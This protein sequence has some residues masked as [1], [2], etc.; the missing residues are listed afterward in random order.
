MTSRRR[1]GCQVSSGLA[2][3]MTACGLVMQSSGAPGSCGLRI[4]GRPLSAHRGAWLLR[5]RLLH[6]QQVPVLR[7]RRQREVVQ[8]AAPCSCTCA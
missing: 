4:R 6:A 5:L 3:I 2:L 8:Q 1:P 7:L